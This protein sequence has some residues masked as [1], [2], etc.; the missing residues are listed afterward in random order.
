MI[1]PLRIDTLRVDAFSTLR[2]DVI[3]VLRVGVFG[4]L[5]GYEGVGRDLVS[6]NV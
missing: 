3:G 1:G 5:G 4:T 2:I 6:K